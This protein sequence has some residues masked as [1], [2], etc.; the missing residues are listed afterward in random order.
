MKAIANPT[1]GRVTFAVIN[2]D[3][4]F[5]TDLDQLVVRMP[6]HI[7]NALTLGQRFEITFKEAQ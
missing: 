6:L 3:T 2:S 7:A 1:K 5:T 4:D